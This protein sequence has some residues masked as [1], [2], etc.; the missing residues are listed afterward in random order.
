[1][2]F[3]FPQMVPKTLNMISILIFRVVFILNLK[4]C[5]FGY[6]NPKSIRTKIPP[7]HLSCLYNLIYQ[8]CLI[9]NRLPN[10]VFTVHPCDQASKGGCED[11]CTKNGDKAECSC[12]KP[13][14]ELNSDKKSCGKTMFCENYWSSRKNTLFFIK[15][16]EQ[17]NSELKFKIQFRKIL[18]LACKCLH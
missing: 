13:G 1:M 6:E 4:K 17:R 16:F 18:M 5:N 7:P 9:N 10:V 15:T 2:A 12:S 3:N 11:T 8:G 14:F